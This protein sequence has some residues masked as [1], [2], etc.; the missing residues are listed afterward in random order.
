MRVAAEKAFQPKYVAIVSVTDDHRSSGTRL[1][2]QYPPQDQCAQDAFPE[3]SLADEH[4]TQALGSDDDSG[5]RP[6]GTRIDQRRPAG[7]LLQPAEKASRA[8]GHNVF[9]DTDGIVAG[10]PDIPAEDDHHSWGM[11]PGGGQVLARLKRARLANSREAPHL[12][13]FQNRKQLVPARGERRNL[14]RHRRRAPA[15]E[16]ARRPFAQRRATSMIA[17]AKARGA[18][19]GR[20]W[21]TPPVIVRCVYWPE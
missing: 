2:Q 9:F 18:S 17:W 13:L 20:L 4:C 19:C 11:A 1:E 12:R 5:H 6:N 14:R 10:N 21:P 7:E 15:L 3:C 16:Q 8:V